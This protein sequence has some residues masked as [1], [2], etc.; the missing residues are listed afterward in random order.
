M[1][2]RDEPLPCAHPAEARPNERVTVGRPGPP[3]WGASQRT[4]CDLDAQLQQQAA[5]ARAATKRYIEIL[6]AANTDEE[7]AVATESGR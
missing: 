3:L 2:G 6:A 5:A 1:A 7:C 4:S